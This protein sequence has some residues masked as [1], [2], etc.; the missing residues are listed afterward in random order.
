[1]KKWIFIALIF[2]F[3][4]CSETIDFLPTN[5]YNE[6]AVW[7]N[8]KSVTLY[9]NSFYRIFT[10]YFNYGIRPIGGDGTMSDG[11]T[12]IA[13]YSSNSPGEGTANLI[14]TQDGYTS[15][16]ANHFGIWAN[17][18]AWNRRMLEFFDDLNKYGGKFPE[19]TRKRMEAE[20]RFF[21]GYVFFLCYRAHGP[22]IIRNSL[23]DP[24]A[25]PI[26]TDDEC[27]NFIEKEFDF[28]AE[29][30]PDTWAATDHGRVTKW[31]SLAMKS[32]AMLYAKRWQKAADAAKKVID[33]GQFELEKN[34]SDIFINDK[35]RISKEHIL[36]KKYNHTFGIMHGIDEM[37]VPSGDVAGKGGRLCPTQELVDAY[38]K[39][40]GTEMSVNRPFDSTMYQNREARFYA[41]ILY[42][43]ATWKGRKV[44]TWV[45]ATP[46]LGN[47]K[48]KFI[49]YNSN[50]YPNTTVTG[51]YFKK[52]A[53]E[54]NTTFDLTYR[55]SD[56]DCIE[57]RLA[58]VYLNLAEAYSNLNRAQ[59]ATQLLLTIRNRSLKTKT[60]KL[61]RDLPSE[62][63]KERMLE[64][65]LEGHRFW[66]LRRWGLAESR[67]HDKKWHGALITRQPNGTFKYEQV[68]VDVNKRIYLP[69][70]NRFPYP[71]AELN[72]NAN[73][74]TQPQGWQ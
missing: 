45:G 41:T 38:L 3:S 32:R 13:K 74:K 15:P 56:Q 21:R 34:F 7:E 61:N 19:A 2:V 6:V 58:E 14:M 72:N 54:A 42:N 67:L 11:L 1:M 4:A 16:A 57:I 46:A 25:M 48:D 24:V 27:W 47:G 22:F 51:Y 62:I 64:F 63:E 31:A 20:V 40:D 5:S 26:N 65:A 73:I 9:V 44:E 8:E 70:F 29:N 23:Q 59:D 35:N 69:K 50:P 36:V 37:I 53:D 30:L 52:L 39:D 10:E 60:S 71:V 49:A 66:D 55:R 17:A 12:D 18:Y 28:A 33:S 68:E 43:G